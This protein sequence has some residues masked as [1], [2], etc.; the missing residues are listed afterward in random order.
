VKVC[1]LSTRLATLEVIQGLLC[2]LPLPPTLHS[3]SRRPPCLLLMVVGNWSGS[4]KSLSTRRKSATFGLPLILDCC[5]T[6]GKGPACAGGGVHP[7]HQSCFSKGDKIRG[8]LRTVSEWFCPK[9][10]NISVVTIRWD[11]VGTQSHAGLATKAETVHKIVENLMQDVS[12]L[13]S[14]SLAF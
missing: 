12:N 13:F 3:L 9:P 10:L 8:Q 6:E 5:D 1:G 2:P 4:Q 11:P 7:R 14:I